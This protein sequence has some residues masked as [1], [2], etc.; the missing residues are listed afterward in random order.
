MEI[1][2][3]AIWKKKHRILEFFCW[4][5]LIYIKDLIKNTSAYW[6]TRMMHDGKFNKWENDRQTDG[7]THGQSEWED[8]GTGGQQQFIDYRGQKSTDDRWQMAEDKWQMTIADD[9]CKMT[10]ENDRWQMTNAD[11]KCGWQMR[12]ADDRWQWSLLMLRLSCLFCR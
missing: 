5:F 10:N 9:R 12:N 4:R 7:N 8:N 2:K 1:W 6:H 3:I 11:D